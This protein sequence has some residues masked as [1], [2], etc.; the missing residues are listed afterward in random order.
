MNFYFSFTFISFNFFISL[1]H[2]LLCLI[3]YLF[4]FSLKD[5]SKLSV[6]RSLQHQL[7]KSIS[8]DGHVLDIGGGDLTSY[9]IFL[10]PPSIPL[11]IST[12]VGIHQY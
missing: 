6:C 10:L 8:L 2:L 12:P 1:S 7:I 5:L 4:L 11:S 9:E 3:R